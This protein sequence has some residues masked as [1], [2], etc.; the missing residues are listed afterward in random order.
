MDMVPDVHQSSC[1]YPKAFRTY[2]SR[3]NLAT[4]LPSSVGTSRENA[5]AEKLHLGSLYKHTEY[6]EGYAIFHIFLYPKP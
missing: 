1:P 5:P 6:Y 2:D 4:N 3:P